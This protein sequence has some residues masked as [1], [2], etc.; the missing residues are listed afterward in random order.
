MKIIFLI[1]LFTLS[2]NQVF[3]KRLKFQIDLVYK[4]GIDKGVTLKNEL[5][6]ID[7]VELNKVMNVKLKGRLR[8]QLYFKRK[9]GE[10]LDS[11]TGLICKYKIF[12]IENVELH[13]SAKDNFLEFN[14]EAL[15]ELKGKNHSL[16]IGLKVY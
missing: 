3:A 6:K 15:V 2:S 12:N 14:K 16:I 4:V 9:I 11:L 7:Y 1:I 8:T 10:K 13:R 5:H